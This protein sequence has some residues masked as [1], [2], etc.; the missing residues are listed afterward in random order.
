MLYLIVHVSICVFP[1]F[2]SW[3][4]VQLWITVHVPAHTFPVFPLLKTRTRVEKEKTAV[5]FFLRELRPVH[6]ELTQCNFTAVLPLSGLFIPPCWAPLEKTGRWT[7]AHG[8]QVPLGAVEAPAIPPPQ[9]THTHAHTAQSLARCR[10]EQTS[11]NNLEVLRLL[12]RNLCSVKCCLIEQLLMPYQSKRV[13]SCKRRQ[14][15]GEA[16]RFIPSP[17]LSLALPLSFF[18]QLMGH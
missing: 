8:K 9:H 7:S 14:K 15:K 11:I 5:G 3:W 13:K 18:V 4:F 10:F 16:F 17:S 1:L 6:A 12:S 2:L